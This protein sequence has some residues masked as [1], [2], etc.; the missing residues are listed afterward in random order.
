MKLSKLFTLLVISFLITNIV[1]SQTKRALLIGIENY[2]CSPEQKLQ[3]LKGP[4][5]DVAKINSL[6]LSKFLFSNSNIKVILNDEAT[7]DN[8]LKSLKDLT[9]S[10]QKGDIVV[11]YYTGHG[12]LQM[13][14]LARDGSKFDEGIVTADA[15]QTGLLIRDKELAPIFSNMIDKGAVLTCIYDCCHSGGLSRGFP[16]F[17]AGQIKSAPPFK[18]IDAAD[19]SIPPNIIEKGA[20]V[21]TACTKEQNANCLNGISVFTEALYTE[22]YSN[23]IS[24]Q[25]SKLFLRVSARVQSS[26]TSQEPLIFGNER[27]GRTIFGIEPGSLPNVILIASIEKTDGTIMLQGGRA[28][29]LEKGCVLRKY[30]PDG[31]DS[32][33]EVEIDSVMN[34]N[35]STIK[36]IKGTEKDVKPGDLFFVEK[37][38]VAGKYNL[39]VWIPH[40]EKD[41]NELKK[42]ASYVKTAL[43]GKVQIVD[44][45]TNESQV[46]VLYYND[47]WFLRNAKGNIV[48]GSNPGVLDI[49]KNMQ[50]GDKLF[51]CLPLP[52]DAYNYLSEK[53]E[54]KYTAIQSVTSPDL[55]DYFLCGRY[56][57]KEIEYSWIRFQSSE[58]ENKST[59]PVRT[60]WL[61]DSYT[62]LADSL[63]NYSAKLSKVKA[64]LDINNPYDNE[65]FPYSLAVKR[66]SDGMIT[67]GETSLDTGDECILVLTTD[68]EKISKW[69]NK[70]ARYI[71]VVG[72][73]N[74]G[75][76]FIL[77]PQNSV[78]D[79][80]MLPLDL[81]TPPS[82]IELKDSKF[83]I[84]CPCGTD[85]YILITSDSRIT[86]YKALK[87]EGVV[88]DS[89][90]RKG[91]DPFSQFKEYIFGPGNS[92]RSRDVTMTTSW[93]AN[94]IKIVSKAMK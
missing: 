2:N 8:I 88:F 10:I 94:N 75:A 28:M 48:L 73:D 83:R 19:P 87:Q 31:K 13:N 38:K 59:L 57:G 23:S 68:N 55:A 69:N 18:E 30:S 1:L 58:T 26:F 34:L 45:P 51:I 16:V 25:V 50:T 74:S 56:N 78:L 12:S 36:F 53:Y 77:Y 54:S 90:T 49:S 66:L 67:T 27:M 43:Q 70:K 29:G 61:K 21:I 7:R 17:N 93:S 11:F 76:S 14:S 4:V 72:I 6:L 81:K 92:A 71:Y 41:F 80:D 46:Q 65:N 47:G 3:D 20:L 63:L 9:E 85:T 15:C 52:A 44:D 22:L 91:Y 89:G 35:F 62:M 37:W 5:N 64:W 86:D 24:E 84:Q 79:N 32:G 42:F 60:T 82:I 33:I 39:S 40:S